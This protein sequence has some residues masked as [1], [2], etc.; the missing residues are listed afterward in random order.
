MSS[1]KNLAVPSPRQLFDGWRVTRN[2]PSSPTLLDV[3]KGISDTVE[4][5]EGVSG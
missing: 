4:K 5:E 1:G 3:T 2:P